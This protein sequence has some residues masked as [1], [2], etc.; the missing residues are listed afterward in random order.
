KKKTEQPEKTFP[1]IKTNGEFC[2]IEVDVEE[3]HT[4]GGEIL[5]TL[6]RWLNYTFC[7]QVR[8]E[9]SEKKARILELCTNY[10][11]SASVLEDNTTGDNCLI[12]H[13]LEED[14]QLPPPTANSLLVVMLHYAHIINTIKDNTQT[15]ITYNHG[16]FIML[17]DYHENP[18]GFPIWRKGSFDR[19]LPSCG[20][21][22]LSASRRDYGNESSWMTS[23]WMR[24]HDSY[25]DLNEPFVN[26]QETI[27]KIWLDL[28]LAKGLK[29]RSY[30]CRNTGPGTE[31]TVFAAVECE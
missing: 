11:V 3:K 26:T 30:Q 29:G 24:I 14:L 1:T 12:V 8:K 13:T 31:C 16:G 28:L 21:H 7:F 6:I 2:N 27:V 4:I 18:V 10:N 17:D 9:Q 15:R 19:I 20:S 22:S 5:E 23:S 25:G